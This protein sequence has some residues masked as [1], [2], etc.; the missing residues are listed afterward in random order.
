MALRSVLLVAL[1]VLPVVAAQ[2]EEGP[3][4]LA[5]FKL[6]PQKSDP[7]QDVT[8]S[9]YPG[10][11]AYAPCEPIV[12]YEWD[13]D[14]DGL[15]E[16]NKTAA[17]GGIVSVQRFEENG[18]YPVAL[19]V[20]DACG[21]TSVQV[22]N[23][24]VG[25]PVKRW[26]WDLVLNSHEAFLKATWLVIWVS[27]V[28]LAVGLPLGVLMGIARIAPLAPVRWVAA[29]Y[30]ELLRGTPLLVQ[31]FIVWLALPAITP[32]KFTP[33]TAGIIALVVNT[34]AYQAEIVRAGIQAIP[35]G[36]QEAALA[37]GFT[38]WQAMRHIVLPQALRLVI[39]PLTN[40]YVIL[41]K[42]TS[43]LSTIGVLELMLVARIIGSRYYTIAEPLFAVALIYFVLTFSASRLAAFAERKLA[44]PG[45]GIHGGAGK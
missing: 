16:V 28:V 17:E 31:I 11:R 38:R 15:F 41:V 32:F 19:R 13:W 24:T 33:L 37:M 26:R 9:A 40:E 23:L 20:T 2:G 35:S 1:L 6:S 4:P 43:L 34:S 21:Q 39:P 44:I 27:T 7:G 10:S 45:L 12:R 18:L 25:A 14:G 8:A 42:D 3:P 29:A 30:I 36:Q 5:R 22:E